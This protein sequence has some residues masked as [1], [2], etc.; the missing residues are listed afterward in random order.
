MGK[1]PAG[2]FY[3]A[4]WLRDKAL[5]LASLSTQGAWMNILAYMWDGQDRGALRGSFEQIAKLAQ[6][7]KEEMERFINDA[8]KTKFCDISVSDNGEITL[9]NRR[10]VRDQQDKENNRIRQRRFKL[11]RQDNAKITQ[12]KRKSN[13]AS[14]SSSSTSINNNKITDLLG[15]LKID[16]LWR[17]FKKHR[18]KKKSC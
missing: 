5:H 8:N 1:A 17:E 12:K 3:F 9:V 4:D 6:A 13:T 11:S 16:A 2:Q 15:Q 7:N 10:M 18:K 14:S